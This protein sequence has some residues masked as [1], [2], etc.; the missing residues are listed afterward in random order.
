MPAQGGAGRGS[1]GG[2]TLVEIMIVIALLALATR[3]VVLNAD[4]FLPGW[5][6]NAE[7]RKMSSR[8]GFLASE[9]RLQGRRFGLEI[10]LD[11]HSFR[12][13][14]PPD[15]SLAMVDEEIPPM[16]AMDWQR[17]EGEIQFGYIE[18]G[19]K[20]QLY[21]SGR[22]VL[23]FDAL[24]TT[25]EAA[26]HLKNPTHEK[27]KTTLVVHGLTAEVDLEPGEF[28]LQEVTEHAF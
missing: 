20:G 15:F 14:L 4:A 28:H 13:L 5:Q 27:I 18:I 25:V 7:A 24:G 23:P 12:T 17:L 19:T 11:T 10:D 8:I 9:A 6:L 21:R 3:M 1:R 2:F 16:L 22:V 26:I